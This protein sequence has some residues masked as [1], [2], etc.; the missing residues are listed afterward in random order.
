MRIYSFL[1]HNIKRQLIY[2]RKEVVDIKSIPMMLVFILFLFGCHGAQIEEGKTVLHIS[3]ATSLVNV[4]DE[5]KREFSNQYEQIELIF[6]YGSSGKLAKQIELGA[7]ADLFL[8]AS[9]ADMDYLITSKHIE[10]TT[11]QIYAENELVFVVPKNAP[12]QANDLEY[13]TNNTIKYIAVAEPE[14]VPLG[15]YTKH[16]LE[17]LGLWDEIKDKFV[18]GKDARQVT[19]YVKTGNADA[20]IIYKSDAVAEEDIKIIHSFGVDEDMSIIYQAGTVTNTE[21]QQAVEAFMN[22]IMREETQQIFEEFGFNK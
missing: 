14:N 15:R 22:F 16:A 21:N 7:P 9:E 10:V 12:E 3:A 4:L 2:F 20:G 11:V 17:K 18:Y 5:I 1:R 8:S 13:L 6:N 19:T